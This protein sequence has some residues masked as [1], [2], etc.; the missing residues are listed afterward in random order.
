MEL[1][2]LTGLQKSQ[3]AEWFTTARKEK[4]ERM[5][6]TMMAAQSQI[7]KQAQTVAAHA[8]HSTQAQT[9]YRSPYG[10][11]RNEQQQLIPRHPLPTP[12]V[13][14]QAQHQKEQ[15]A[16]FKAFAIKHQFKNL[17]YYKLSFEEIESGSDAKNYS[18]EAP[19]S[20]LFETF[21]ELLVVKPASGCVVKNRTKHNKGKPLTSQQ[22]SQHLLEVDILFDLRAHPN[23]VSL[24]RV[25]ESAS[26]WNI[27]LEY[28]PDGDLWTAIRDRGLG[29]R[30]EI[31]NTFSQILK[32]VEFCH[33]RG[34][35]HRDLKPENIVMRGSQ[36]A[37]SNFSTATREQISL[38]GCG[39]MPFMSPECYASYNNDTETPMPYKLA[40]SD[41]WSLGVLLITL[42]TGRRPW[43]IPTVQ[44]QEYEGFWESREFRDCVHASG[45][46]REILT[47]K[48]LN[49]DPQARS[50]ATQLKKDIAETYSRFEAI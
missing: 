47:E 44:D 5:H 22:R 26:T 39:T 34:I 46:S 48:I 2:R 3:I 29:T 45:V 43:T 16:L 31:R 37:L 17:D 35:Y 41:I 14:D 30:E 1:M 49:H 23:V 25:I 21:D 50:N 7:A 13:I 18:R 27:V 9:P 15:E 11:P 10:H 40:P 20:S 28:F 8:L 36:V 6:R 38:K 42:T 12:P 33:G 4:S 24:F 32:G 19:T